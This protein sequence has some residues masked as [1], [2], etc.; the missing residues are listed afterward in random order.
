[1]TIRAVF[2]QPSVQKYSTRAMTELLTVKISEL[3]VDKLHQMSVQVE[4]CTQSLHQDRVAWHLAVK[5]LRQHS[6]QFPNSC[7]QAEIQTHT[8]WQ[9]PPGW[10]TNMHTV[11]ATIRLKY[12]HAHCDSYHQ[13]EIQTCTMWQLPSGWNTN[14][15]NVTATIRLKYKHAQCDSYH[16]AEIQTCT[17]WQLPLG[18]NTNMHTVTATIR[19]KYKHAHCDSYHQAEIQ[20]CTMWRLPSG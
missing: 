13:A 4:A 17:M 18:W 2:H 5:L 10:N 12:K 3:Y 8:M 1:M 19:L 7:H 6:L 9:L 20:T 11:T 16:Q 14:T 15:H